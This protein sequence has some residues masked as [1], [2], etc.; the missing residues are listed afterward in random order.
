[1][2][3]SCSALVLFVLLA[4]GVSLAVPA[5]D[6][7]DTAFD[8]SETLPFESFPLFSIMMPE[9]VAA[10][11]TVLTC[12]SPRC[13]DSTANSRESYRKHRAGTAHSVLDSLTILKRSLRC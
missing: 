6:V 2:T 10:A 4:F 1:M 9:T 11:P 7:S 13:L 3:K 12:V 5:E 8:E